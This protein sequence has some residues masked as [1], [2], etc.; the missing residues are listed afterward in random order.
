MNHRALPLNGVLRPE[1]DDG[2]SFIDLDRLFASVLRRAMT[3][4][5]ATALFMML[6]AAYLVFTT[7]VYTSMT[8]I[9]LDENLARYAEEELASPQSKQQADTQISSAVEILKSNKMALRRGATR[10]RCTVR[11]S[12]PGAA[13][14]ASTTAT[15]SR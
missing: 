7:P 12:A 15:A 2:N 8:Q 11:C 9:L 6:G 13:T 10:P 5:L 1:K 14:T 3:I 4:G